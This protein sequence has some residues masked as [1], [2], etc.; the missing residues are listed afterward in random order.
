M[1]MRK[2]DQIQD[3]E[4]MLMG[5]IWSVKERGETRMTPRFWVTEW[6][7]VTFTEMGR[8]WGETDLSLEK[9]ENKTVKQNLDVQIA[10][11]DL[12]LFQRIL[13]ISNSR[14]A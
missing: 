9:T 6:V 14:D 1:E 13:I 12:K 3:G 5:W 8:S 7:M 4:P 10:S 11:R 2:S